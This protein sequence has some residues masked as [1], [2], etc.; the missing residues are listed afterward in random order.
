MRKCIVFKWEK[1]EGDSFLSR[2][3]DY[4]AMFHQFGCNY[5]EHGEFG[6]GNF[7]A[8]V[9]EKADGTIEMPCADMVQFTETVIA[10]E[11]FSTI[12]KVQV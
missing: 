8:A 10:V 7:T 4:E 11:G 2:V 9:V 5:E 1:K 12:P 3:P 6:P